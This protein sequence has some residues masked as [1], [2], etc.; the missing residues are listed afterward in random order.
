MLSL[1]LTRLLEVLGEAANRIPPEQH[2]PYPGIPWR[3][4]IG[5]RNRLIHDY[6][7]VDLSILWEIVT[8]DLPALVGELDT[9]LTPE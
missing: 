9:I 7:R 4:L 8:R 1:A 5:L 3:R 6:D 2:S